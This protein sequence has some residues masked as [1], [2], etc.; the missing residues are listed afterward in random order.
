ML[1]SNN[2]LISIILSFSIWKTIRSNM[3]LNGSHI[4]KT[5][6]KDNFSEE[7][8]TNS[9]SRRSNMIFKDLANKF[10]ASLKDI[11]ETVL[12]VS[13]IQVTYGSI[14]VNFLS[15]FLVDKLLIFFL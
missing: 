3:E 7:I 13:I 8:D 5:E 4:V 11:S 10:S 6:L 15:I 14:I 1:M 12:G 9:S 2:I